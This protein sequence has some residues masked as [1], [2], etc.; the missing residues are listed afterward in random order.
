MCVWGSDSHC[1]GEGY[2]W[3]RA[4]NGSQPPQNLKNEAVPQFLS[5]LMAT[6]RRSDLRDGWWA[7]LRCGGAAEFV[8]NR[9]RD[10][11][12]LLSGSH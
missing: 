8:S 6:N 12:E 3:S 10:A 5:S 9:E 11:C 1:G 2:R 7:P 4:G